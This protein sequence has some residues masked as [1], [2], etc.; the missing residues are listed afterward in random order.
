MESLEV[1]VLLFLAALVI[2]YFIPTGR[3]QKIERNHI[4][5]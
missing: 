1:L 4:D 5:E 2:E 3:H